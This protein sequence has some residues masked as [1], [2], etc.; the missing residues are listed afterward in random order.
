MEL[1]QGQ[2]YHWS[3]AGL[4]VEEDEM[5]VSFDMISLFTNIPIDEA[6]QVIR[7]KL[8]G[9]EMLADRT[10]LSPDRVAELLEACLR[11]TYFSYRGDFYEQREGAAM[12]SPVSAVM[13]NLYMEFFEG[14]ALRSAPAKPRLWKRYVDDTFC[15]VKKGTV[16]G[17]QSR[18]A[19]QLPQCLHLL[20]ISAF[21]S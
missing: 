8:Q 5:L 1:T 15:I 19:E 7:D 16:K 14:L 20:F 17:I 2:E 3:Q 10:T 11:S 18:E 4:K 21:C 9:D 13:A 6:A 12:G